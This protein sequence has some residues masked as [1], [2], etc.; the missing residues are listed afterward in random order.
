MRTDDEVDCA[1]LSAKRLV[2][3]FDVQTPFNPKLDNDNMVT[4]LV[5]IVSMYLLRCS[6]QFGV[7]LQISIEQVE[8]VP[9]SVRHLKFLKSIFAQKAWLKL[10]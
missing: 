8:N 6:L 1:V 3:S 7:I 5:I 10:N 2:G 4:W 9:F